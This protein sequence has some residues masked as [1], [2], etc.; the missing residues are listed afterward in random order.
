MECNQMLTDQDFEEKSYLK[1]VIKNM[2]Y[3]WQEHVIIQH[4]EKN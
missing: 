2:M 4:G 1:I 3:I